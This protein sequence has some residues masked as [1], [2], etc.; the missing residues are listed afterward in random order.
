M[1]EEL[2][3]EL[4]KLCRACSRGQLPQETLRQR[5]DIYFPVAAVLSLGCSPECTVLLAGTNAITTIRR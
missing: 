3:A 4:V 1:E 5:K 2:G